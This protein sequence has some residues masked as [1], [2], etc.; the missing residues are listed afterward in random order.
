MVPTDAGF[1]E[2]C[3]REYL[4][5]STWSAKYGPLASDF[6]ETCLIDSTCSILAPFPHCG[7]NPRR[8]K[9][10][11]I[12]PQWKKDVNVPWPSIPQ[13]KKAVTP[14]CS[15]KPSIFPQA[16]ETAVQE[17]EEEPFFDLWSWENGV[18]C[19]ID[20]PGEPGASTDALQVNASSAPQRNYPPSYLRDRPSMDR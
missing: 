19:A 13:G 18:A 20:L 11:S 15:K 1:P 8:P 12:V 5:G 6:P 9:G 10:P 2:Y 4:R 3:S 17:D 7:Y 14:R 16:E